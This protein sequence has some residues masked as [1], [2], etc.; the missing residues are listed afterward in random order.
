MEPP[1]RPTPIPRSFNEG[2]SPEPLT[3]GSSD[4]GNRRPT[5]P[6]S[7]PRP[8]TPPAKPVSESPSNVPLSDSG[9]KSRSAL[10]SHTLPPAKKP[11][12]DD[13][14]GAP[15]RPGILIEKPGRD[16]RESFGLG[17]PRSPFGAGVP[18]G[19]LEVMKKDGEE[20][21]S[22]P[23]EPASPPKPERTSWPPLGGKPARSSF[24]AGGPMAPETEMNAVKKPEFGKKLVP[25]PPGAISEVPLR[26]LTDAQ[27]SASRSSSSDGARS[28]PLSVRSPG[29]S[30]PPPPRPPEESSGPKLPSLP[31]S[32]GLPPT[33]PP[34]A[35][36]KVDRNIRPRRLAILILLLIGFIGG[37]IL[38]VWIFLRGSSTTDVTPVPS[39]DQGL[40]ASPPVSPPVVGGNQDSDGDGLTDDTEAQLGTD[41]T[42]P[43]TD[44]D[45]YTDKQELD[46]G[47]DPLGPGKLDTDR[48]GLFD[49][50]EAC[51]NTDPRTPDTDGDGYLDGQEVTNGYNPTIPSPNDKLTTAPTCPS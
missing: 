41:L 3:P 23:K 33:T 36:P 9:P 4:G 50:A 45:G 38:A 42:R 6:P 13:A 32:S 30:V 47:Y 12:E 20:P 15:A 31:P 14:D 19:Q 26:P 7:A 8:T 34:P 25:P 1:A 11:S 24:D 40:F 48:D 44:G 21:P 35:S 10:S 49:P 2:G 51:W 37:I 22:L 29:L 43:D 39:A 17:K 27:L 5:P 46:A 18:L 16:E 28:R